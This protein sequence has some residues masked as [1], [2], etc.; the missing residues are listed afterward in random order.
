MI[1][2]SEHK[3]IESHQVSATP[4]RTTQNDGGFLTV[5]IVGWGVGSDE[6]G[7]IC[8]VG[9]IKMSSDISTHYILQHYANAWMYYCIKEISL[10]QTP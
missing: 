2:R 6:D 10:K 3:S 9:Y 7:R 5:F 1:V 4:D 8:R